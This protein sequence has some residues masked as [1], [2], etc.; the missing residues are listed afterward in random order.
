MFGTP[1]DGS[2]STDARPESGEQRRPLRQRVRAHG[3]AFLAMVLFAAGPIGLLR[4]APAFAATKTWTGA[5]S[6]AWST[7]GNW[8]PSGAPASTDDVVI[9]AITNGS[10]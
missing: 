3:T 6:T 10:V 9:P 1:S 5:S 8:S 2:T 7:S 4:A